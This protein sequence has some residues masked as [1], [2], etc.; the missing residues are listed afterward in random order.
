[1]DE[2]C[3]SHDVSIRQ[4]IDKGGLWFGEMDFGM[5]EFGLQLIRSGM[6]FL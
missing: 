5:I 1:M 4:T 2:G 6:S 3:G